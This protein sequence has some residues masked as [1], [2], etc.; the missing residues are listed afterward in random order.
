[1]SWEIYREVLRTVGADLA[2]IQATLHHISGGDSGAGWGALGPIVLAS[3]VATYHRHTFLDKYLDQYRP[4]RHD[5]EVRSASWTRF[6]GLPARGQHVVQYVACRDSSM[7][8]MV[9]F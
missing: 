8:A 1:M 7:R 4:A 3:P 5:R 9:V 2:C 6:K